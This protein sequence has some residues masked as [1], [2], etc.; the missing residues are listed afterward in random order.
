M[1]LTEPEIAPLE[2]VACVSNSEARSIVTLRV[3]EERNRDVAEREQT[4]WEP[5]K[6]LIW[7]DDEVLQN[8]I[9]VAVAAKREHELRRAEKDEHNTVTLPPPV[10]DTFDGM[11]RLN[12]GAT[13]ENA[14]ENEDENPEAEMA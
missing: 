2:G 5:E 9:A 12:E 13:N 11:G 14:K 10:G 8:E 6:D 1:A 7:I 4:E 3:R